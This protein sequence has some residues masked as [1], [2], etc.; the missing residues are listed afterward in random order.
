MDPCAVCGN[1]VVPLRKMPVVTLLNDY[2]HKFTLQSLQNGLLAQWIDCDWLAIMQYLRL[3]KK[4]KKIWFQ[5]NAWKLARNEC[6]QIGDVLAGFLERLTPLDSLLDTGTKG[7]SVN[8]QF[9]FTTKFALDGN[10][11]DNNS[12]FW[13]VDCPA[14]HKQNFLQYICEHELVSPTGKIDMTKDHE[15]REW[16][17]GLDLTWNIRQTLDI[18]Q[19]KYLLRHYRA[20]KTKIVCETCGSCKKKVVCTNV[21]EHVPCTNGYLYGLSNE[22]LSGLMMLGFADNIEAILSQANS[23]PWK[24]PHPYKLAIAKKVAEPVQKL[25]KLLDS[26]ASS[27]VSQ[28][29]FV[30]A[31]FDELLA[32]FQTIDGEPYIQGQV[33]RHRIGDS[34]WYANYVNNF[35]LFE[36]STYKSLRSFVKAHY[37][38]VCLKPQANSWKECEWEQNGEWVIRTIRNK[39]KDEQL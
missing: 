1:S 39:K 7:K 5:P 23:S 26:L 12:G 10:Y 22:S 36:G 31:S 17:A 15:T 8:I 13:D 25:T 4:Q 27:R 21:I 29:A 33:V 18:N 11:T 35:I 6:P 3:H 34:C 9:Q 37:T 16:L 19:R 20:Y 2:V 32:L 28:S 14:A 30:R 38:V 24:P